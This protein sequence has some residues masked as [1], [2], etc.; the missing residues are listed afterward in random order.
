MSLVVL[1]ILAVVWA[2]FL[3]PQVVRARAEKTPADSIGAFRT[4]L[5]VL[6]RAA[7]AAWGRPAAR[8]GRSQ[9]FLA[10]PSAGP[11][12]R[13]SAAKRRRDVVFGLLAGMAGSLLLGLIPAL[14]VMLGL[15]LVLDV[16]FVAYLGV[17]ARVRTNAAEREMKVHY[18]P[19]RGMIGPEPALL[20]RRSGS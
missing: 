9:S 5:S 18:L 3:I 12:R 2:V 11:A 1:L 20:L 14:R 17:L 4:Q 7:P 19:E 6:E 10:G 8:V 15:H 13:T 16:L